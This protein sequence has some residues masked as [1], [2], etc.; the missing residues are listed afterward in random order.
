M[1]CDNITAIAVADLGQQ[2]GF[3]LDS[4]EDAL[5]AA[6]HAAFDLDD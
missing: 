6:I 4:H 1:N 2:I 3:I 5:T